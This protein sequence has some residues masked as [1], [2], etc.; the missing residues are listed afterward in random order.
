MIYK[1]VEVGGYP[2]DGS[3]YEL[4][5]RVKEMIDMGFKPLGGINSFQESTGGG[6]H[7]RRSQAMIKPE[8]L[9]EKIFN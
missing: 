6:I 2:K 3:T 7:T 8:T 4:E 5:K 1:V 9:F